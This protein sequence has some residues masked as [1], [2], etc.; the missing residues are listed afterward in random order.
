MGK[1]DEVIE[2]L[3]HIPH[4]VPDPRDLPNILDCTTPIVYLDSAFRSHLLERTPPDLQEDASGSSPRHM[5]TLADGQRA[6][7]IDTKRDVVILWKYDTKFPAYMDCDDKAVYDESVPDLEKVGM[8]GL[9]KLKEDGKP[10]QEHLIRMRIVKDAGWPGI[11]Y[12][13]T[14]WDKEK[15]ETETEEYEDDE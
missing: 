5:L 7:I 8:G 4:F 15:A 12:E 6:V 9:W 11:N 13:G 1:A 10:D 3:R 14:G 2:L